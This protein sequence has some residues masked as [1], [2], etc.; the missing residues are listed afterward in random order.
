MEVSPRDVERADVDV[1]ELTEQR[2]RIE[3]GHRPLS[4]DVRIVWT[5]QLTQCWPDGLPVTVPW[6]RGDEIPDDAEALVCRG[7]A[8]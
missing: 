1:L 5:V 8:S 6:E 2:L 3:L 7:Q 4:R